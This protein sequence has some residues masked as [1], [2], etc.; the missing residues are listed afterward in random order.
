MAAQS[1]A[2]RQEIT[3][4]GRAA[5]M[6]WKKAWPLMLSQTFMLVFRWVVTA[7]QA[8][9]I[10]IT[11]PLWQV[12][13]T[14]PM[15]PAVP[16]PSV[17]VGVPLLAS[18][19]LVWI[20][21]VPGMIVHTILVVYA[22]LVDQTRMQPEVFSLVFLLWGT[23]PSPTAR[24]IVRVH[25]ISLWFFAGFHKLLSQGFLDET[26]QWML[27]GLPAALQLDRITWLQAGAGCM[28]ALTEMDLAVLALIPRTR[29]IAAILAFLVHGTILFILMPTGH[30][31]N[32]AVWPWNAALALAGFAIIMPWRSSPLESIFNC[33]RIARPLV[34]LLVVAPLGF[35]IGVTDAYLAH[36][37]Y[38]SNTASAEI[39]VSDVQEPENA[40]AASWEAFNVPL[41]PEHR[42]FKQY[43]E[44]TCQPGDTLVISDPRWWYRERN[45]DLQ[46]IACPATS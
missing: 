17:D 22:V 14:P 40:A 33:H 26:A 12:R 19:F 31:W 41:P 28:I 46:V 6:V 35:Y 23:L 27:E 24:A 44:R 16:L 4:L 10:L 5:A 20:V 45:L 30:S 36:H 13:E 15:L 3:T 43:F 39:Y 25:L 1:G 9:T 7:C 21:P 38:S 8:L 32:E 34:V 37:L 2:A 42:V 18:L 29:A 11:W